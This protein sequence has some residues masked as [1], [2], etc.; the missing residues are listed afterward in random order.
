M[1][2]GV[3]GRGRWGTVYART[4]ER[5]A[6]EYRL[7]GRDWRDSGWFRSG[8][9]GAIIASAPASHFPIADELIQAGMPV[10]V[11]KPVCLN[12]P[13]AR[14]LLARAE[15]MRAIVFAGNTRL[16]SPA[17][18]AF[19]EQAL[20][21]GVRSVVASAGSTDAMLGSWW[22]WGGH[23]VAMCLDLDFDPRQ[24]QLRTPDADEPLT[25]R[26]N[27]SLEYRDVEETPKPLDVL[28]GEFVAA[29]RKGE[30]DV[31]G[32]RLGARVVEVLEAMQGAGRGR[33]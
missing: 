5:M 26:V 11:E 15:S 30:P 22:D 17:W 4:L 12:S 6:I 24:A 13:D 28:I 19:R 9:D 29:I 16:Y 14:A 33:R 21:A 8:L 3:I 31:H 27:G 18:R 32:L 25:F 10:L 2:L 23:L 7:D 1:K 20:A